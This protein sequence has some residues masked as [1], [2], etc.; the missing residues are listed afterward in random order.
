MKEL[1]VDTS[2]PL[3]LTSHRVYERLIEPGE[4]IYVLGKIK[5]K[6]GVKTI[7]SEEGAPLVISDRRERQL[8]VKLYGR[9]VVNMLFG[10]LVVL[11]FYYRFTK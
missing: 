10:I 4:Q 7:A 8:L 1:G 3:N 2:S 6:N 5:Y 11:G 9:V